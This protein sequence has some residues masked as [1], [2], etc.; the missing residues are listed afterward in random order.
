[1]YET[2][3]YYS[4]RTLLGKGETSLKEILGKFTPVK[5]SLPERKEAQ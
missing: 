4:I 1:M 5:R 3:V 2:G